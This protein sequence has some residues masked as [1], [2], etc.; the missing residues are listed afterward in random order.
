[1]AYN[2]ITGSGNFT[3]LATDCLIG[4]ASWTGS[5]TRDELY[6]QGLIKT[7]IFYPDL[8]TSSL[9]VA[10]MNFEES[11]QSSYTFNYT[12]ALSG[13]VTN[14]QEGSY[15]DYY[16][17]TWWGQPWDY[18]YTFDTYPEREIDANGQWID[19][20]GGAWK[21]G[22]KFAFLI[23]KSDKKLVSM[24]AV[25]PVS[26]STG[27][28]I[29]TYVSPGVNGFFCFVYNS[30]RS[31]TAGE[32][33]YFTDVKNQTAPGFEKR[34]DLTLID[35]DVVIATTQDP[36]PPEPPIP[37]TSVFIRAKSAGFFFP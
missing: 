19:A 16:V 31:R 27:E 5:T 17:E 25:Y 10:K 32:S 34:A 11:G 26:S 4:S 23:R 9:F 12:G 13:S 36:P 21:S 6:V 35:G 30:A 20:A 2:L 7:D 18:L 29:S 1:M 33:G 22:Y 14:L 8:G 37:E 3:L 15:S 28:S 24:C